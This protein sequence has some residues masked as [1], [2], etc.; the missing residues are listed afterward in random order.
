MKLADKLCIDVA[1]V[2]II[3]AHTSSGHKRGQHEL[4]V[5]QI[6]LLV[7]KYH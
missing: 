6:P 2:G 7:C 1:Y 3:N 5:L 4:K